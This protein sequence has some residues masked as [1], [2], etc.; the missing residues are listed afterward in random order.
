MAVGSIEVKDTNIVEIKETIIGIDE[1]LVK[2][3]AANKYFAKISVFDIFGNTVVLRRAY[4][5]VKVKYQ[6]S[7]SADRE[8]RVRKGQLNKDL[9]RLA[10]SNE[11]NALTK[12]MN[13]YKEQL[14]ANEGCIFTTMGEMLAGFQALAQPVL[15]NVSS[16]METNP[17]ILTSSAV[18]AV[19]TSTEKAAIDSITGKS[20]TNGTPNVCVIAGTS[21]GVSSVYQGDNPQIIGATPNEIKSSVKSVSPVNIATDNKKVLDI[22]EALAGLFLFSSQKKFLKSANKNEETIAPE[23]SYA[24]VLP[25]LISKSSGRGEITSFGDTQVGVFP[26]LPDLVSGQVNLYKTNIASNTLTS[27]IIGTEIQQSSEISNLGG[28][29]TTF[30]QANHVFTTVDTEEELIK[31]IRNIKRD[32]TTTVVHWSHT[33]ANQ[34]LTAYDIDQIHKAQ[35]KQK[36]GDQA[37]TRALTTQEAGIFWHYVILKDGTLQRGRPIELKTVDQMAFAERSIHI[38]FV[39][40]YNVSYS[41]QRETAEQATPDSITPQQWKTFNL[42]SKTLLDVY[43][44]MGILGHSE[45]HN[46][47][48]CPGFDVGEYLYD[49]CGY[50]S[51]YT[52]EDLESADALTVEEMLGRIPNAIVSP[53]PSF[54]SASINSEALSLENTNKDPITGKP[55]ET[56]ADEITDA[57]DGIAFTQNKINNFNIQFSQNEQDAVLK[58]DYYDKKRGVANEALYNLRDDRQPSLE[59]A[60]EYRRILLKAG[61]VYNERTKL[62]QKR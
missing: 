52:D 1:V 48:T 16:T 33:W 26:T 57:I 56:T 49:L 12:E 47:S 8:N 36:L 43:P 60:E 21:K 24:N 6:Y 14:A 30:G 23:T 42:L 20:S 28:N 55:I 11:V 54:A 39:A 22:V 35:Q 44:G 27:E 40:G 25:A 4:P 13:K 15:E 31:E 59:Q 58:N 3:N 10:S 5:V 41:T 17:A 2:T 18:K 46:A 19:N 61:Y 29:I 38:G 45:I 34:F 9:E 62:W 7:T 50:I 32:V 53:A 37:Y 51:P